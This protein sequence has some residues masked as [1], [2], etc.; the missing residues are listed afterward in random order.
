[1]KVNDQLGTPTYLPLVPA[2]EKTGW[3]VN[4]GKEKNPCSCHG[5][6][7]TYEEL[8][9]KKFNTSVILFV[10]LEVPTSGISCEGPE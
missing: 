2:V 7:N 9:Y 6:N 3:D 8:I 4:D 10:I 5:F 1:M